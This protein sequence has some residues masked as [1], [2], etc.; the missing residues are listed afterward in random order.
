MNKIGC[1][2]CLHQCTW[3]FYIF[4]VKQNYFEQCGNGFI[5]AMQPH[6][7]MTT[8]LF[9]TWIYHFIATMQACEAN[10]FLENRHLLIFDCHNSH[11]IVNDVWT[12]RKV[13][14]DPIILPSHTFHTLQ[15]LEVSCFKLFKIMLWKYWNV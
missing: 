14:L 10:M 6:A 15:Q 9:S 3:N 4:K 11:V 2:C 5:M 1:Q 8:C 7:W 12:I 13:G